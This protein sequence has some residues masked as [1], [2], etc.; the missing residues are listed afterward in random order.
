MFNEAIKVLM[1]LLPLFY[2]GCH[3]HP[4]R[5][6]PQKGWSSWSP[7]VKNHGGGGACVQKGFC[8]L[9]AF[10]PFFFSF[11]I[12]DQGLLVGSMYR[13]RESRTMQCKRMCNKLF[14]RKFGAHDSTLSW[15]KLRGSEEKGGNTMESGTFNKKTLSNR[16]ILER[17]HVFFIMFFGSPH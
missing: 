11:Y 8:V 6:Y 15:I 12:L 2:R 1:H 3:P 4:H 9:L 7:F 16:A 10:P 13:P 14:N 5:L 17:S